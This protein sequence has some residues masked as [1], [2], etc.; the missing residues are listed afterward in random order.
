MDALW[1]AATKKII[2]AGID[3]PN[4]AADIATLIGQHDIN[5][6]GYSKSKEGYSYSVN[7]HREQI[8]EAADVRAMRKG[9][10]VLLS[11]GMPVAQIA[12]RP[13][14]AEK[15]MAHIGARW[16]AKRPPSPSAPSARTTCARQ[17]PWMSPARPGSTPR[18][19]C[20]RTSTTSGPRCAA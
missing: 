18:S 11:T 20:A 1:S 4:F 12:L 3:D 10:A 8:M 15:A 17:P 7:E 14:Y 16:S 5:R 13:W 9:T 19:S 6:G 2:G